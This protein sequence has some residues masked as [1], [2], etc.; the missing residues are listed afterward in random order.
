MHPQ[1]TRI[2]RLCPTCGQQF[3]VIPSRIKE[4]RGKYCSN[5]CYYQSKE[6]TLPERFWSKVL[7]GDG[8]TSCW[9]WTGNRD[10]HGYGTLSKT[11]RG[12]RLKAHRVS[13]MIHHGPIPEGLAVC[14]NCPGGDN[15]LCVRPDHLFLG[16]PRA[17]MLDAVTKGQMPRGERSGSAKLTTQQVLDIRHRYAEGTV[18]QPQLAKEHNVTNS[19]ISMI[20]TRKRWSHI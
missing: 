2:S 15:P 1:S 4:G 18:T 10:S 11:R 9:L 13:W 16:T 8:P 3:F 6:R 14:H 7:V 17:N 20:I 5:P 19:L 12:K